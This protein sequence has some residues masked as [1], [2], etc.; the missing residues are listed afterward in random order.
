MYVYVGIH[1]CV[2]VLGSVLSVYYVYMYV[3]VT[4]YSVSDLFGEIRTQLQ[5]TRTRFGFVL[6]VDRIQS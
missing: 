6:V 4:C 1:V 2:G 5:E 3:L